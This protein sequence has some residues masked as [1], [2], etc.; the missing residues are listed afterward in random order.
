MLE[1]I[2]EILLKEKPDYLLVYGDTNSTLAGALAAKKFHIKVIHVEAGLRSYN[3]D[4]PEEI[5][6]ILTDRISDILF[7]PTETAVNNL[8]NEGFANIQSKIILSGDVMQDAALYYKVK[9]D[10]ESKT[11]QDNGLQDGAYA[12]ATIHRAENTDNIDRLREIVT[13]L[14]KVNTTI[15]VVV[16]L[17]PRTGKILATSHIIPE[18]KIIEPVGYF[19]MVQLLSHSKFV[20]TDSGGVQKEAYFFNKYCITLRNETEWI[21][22]VANGYNQLVGASSEKI[23]AAVKSI[24]N[25]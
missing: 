11:L 14:N 24:S 15:P 12:L 25:K 8:M 9:S 3:N 18:F 1:G 16:P 2:E 13:A 7:C 22:L 5:N 20:L 10:Q 17:H 19:D 4:M 6:R 23:L 21:E